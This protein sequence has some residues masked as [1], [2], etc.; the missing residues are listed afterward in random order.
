MAVE[1]ELLLPTGEATDTM[2]A[3]MAARAA[4][5]DRPMVVLYF[6]DFDPAGWQMPLSVARKL[7]ALRTLHHPQLRIAV[8]RVALTLD[9][10]GQFDLP[11]TPLKATEKRAGLWRAAMHHEQTEI[12]A[13]AALRPGILRQIAFDAVAPFFDFTLTTRCKAA[14]TV[15][16]S[17]TAAKIDGDLDIAAAREKIGA[18]YAEL[19]TA[20]RAFNAVRDEALAGLRTEFANL[21]ATIPAP[22]AVIDVPAPDPLFTTADDFATASRKL[23]AQKLYAPGEDA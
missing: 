23:I 14:R 1:G 8:H 18:A 12:D 22:G 13:L 5:D 2:I 10:V 9:Q 19:A 7:Q 16:L 20:V 21:E 3:E 4:A 17:E 15:W 6:S 11:S